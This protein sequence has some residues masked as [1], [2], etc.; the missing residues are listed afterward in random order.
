ME[1]TVY[2]FILRHSL[3]QQF[4]L[5][6]I[7]LASFP[8]LYLSLDL[9]KRIVNQAIG[10][11]NVPTELYGFPVD[12]VSFLMVLSAAFL[13]LVFVNG[14]FKYHIN[15]LKGRLGER[16][17][18]RLRY[19]L[20]ARVLRFPLPRFKKLSAGEIIP[21]ITAEV[22]PLG[23]FIGDAIAQPIF[24]GG[25]LVVYIAFIFVQDPVLGAAAVSLYP[26]QGWLI[27]RLQRH[28]NQLGKRRVRAMR[29]IA[30]RIGETVAGVQEIH[31][32]DASAVHLADIA[33]RYGDIYD[34]RFE[35]YQRKFFIK[36]LNNFINQLTPFFFYS[37]GGYL[38]I[39]GELSFGSLVAVLAA[40]KDLAAP[41][42]ELLDYYQQKEDIRIKYEQVIEQF[43]PPD[44]VDPAILHAEPAEPVRLTGTLQLNNVSLGE[45]GAAKIL[46]G[47]S[48]A[49]PLDRHVA[50]VATG[51]TGR[52]ELAQ[53]YA[54]LLRPSG[55][56][57]VI[58]GRE[59]DQLPESV[60]GRQIAYVGAAP[61][62]FYGTL[63]DN[64]FY[65]LRHRPLQPPRYDAAGEARRQ[66]R[67]REALASA[68]STDDLAADWTDYRAAGCDGPASLA[69]RTRSLLRQL[70]FDHDVYELGLSGTLDPRQAPETAA[71]ILEA[72]R[73]LRQSLSDPAL[74]GLVEPFDPE[75]YN[76]NA[77][78]AENILFGLPVDQRLTLGS[79]ADHPYML[80][81]LDKCGLTEEFIKIGRD[82]AAEMTEMFAGLA[83]GHEFFE[84]YSFISA[85]DLPLYQA[86][87]QQADKDGLKALTPANRSR[88]LSLVFKLVPAR[89]RLS[90]YT[91]TRARRVLEARAAFA[92]DLPDE[93][94]GAIEFFD[95]E[96]YTSS[97]TILDNIL[98]GR[99]AHGKER[100]Q[101]KS[102]GVTIRSAVKNHQ[103][104]DEVVDVGL[105][106]QVG[107]AGGRLSTVQRQ[108]VGVLRALLKNPDLL[109]LND[110]TTAFDPSTRS[111]LIDLVRE[112]QKNKGLIWFV[113]QAAIAEKFDL[114]IVARSGQIIESGSFA[115]LN[116]QGTAFHKLLSEA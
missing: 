7:T 19:E 56:S 100:A 112:V 15:T 33:D 5:L 45:E 82:V 62:L 35:I 101:K 48:A 111:K 60:T 44:L 85:E 95:P 43:Q 108:K 89:H 96:A 53:L 115:E 87:L 16:M 17:L 14:G 70:D 106:F 29:Q 50:L 114:V 8:F 24:Q 11:K 109:V 9:P 71:R 90:H 4:V 22:E 31:N 91:E 34:I 40:Y 84:R 39:K 42:K 20:Y 105:N 27:P 25:T 86:L 97:A 13:A 72:R 65:G 59:F 77:T 57:I 66:R 30:D 73:G 52:D 104:L 93:L 47:V 3:R 110:P 102:L 69:E 94:K 107:V 58:E 113:P 6:A 36:F 64:L 61:Y 75:R 98:F 49:L 81:V 116:R 68:N 55:G 2:K 41:W 12:Q 37:I 88:L 32:H 1:P 54:R 76:V 74:R 28:V 63:R 46:D 18:R 80:S 103:L 79:L 67:V 21:M 78:V 99:V 38:V 92:A 83:P 51:S 10:G 26:F 23:G